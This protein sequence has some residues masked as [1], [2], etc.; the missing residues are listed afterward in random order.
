MLRR[1]ICTVALLFTTMQLIA[2]P[3][4]IS[5][6]GWSRDGKLALLQQTG[7]RWFFAVIDTVT[8]QTLKAIGP[9]TGSKS[10]FLS[11][12]NTTIQSILKTYNIVSA[13]PEVHKGSTF[14]SGGV[15]YAIRVMEEKSEGNDSAG[16]PV[17]KSLAVSVGSSRGDSKT[18]YTWRQTTS[19]PGL[20]GFAIKGVILSPYEK[21]TALIGLEEW[22]NG[23]TTY[24]IIGAHLTI[25]FDPLAQSEN[26]LVQAV[27][28]GQ[29]YICRMYLD[30]G[31]HPDS[32]DKRGYSALLLACRNGKWE[33]AVLLV[34]RGAN[35]EPV[36]NRK[37]RPLHYAAEA[38]R[39]DLCRVLADRGA[40]RDIPDGDGKLPWI[41]AADK[42]YKNL[43][44]FLK[45]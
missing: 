43:A 18:V 38:G 15:K 4:E 26:G 41:L 19:S 12:N 36:D 25:G 13:P 31:A 2:E 11:Q 30:Q 17:F 29:Y 32:T 22:S 37:R 7:G 34:S 28:N 9:S 24:R 33:I 8:D 3:E 5:F 6:Y 14:E 16:R 23:S 1:L 21:R 20:I 27:M 42:G 44:Q 39:T 35:P 10:S 45:P 40:R